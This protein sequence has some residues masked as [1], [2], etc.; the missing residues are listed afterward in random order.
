MVVLNG[1]HV[2]VVRNINNV[3][4]NKP[5]KPRKHKGFRGF[6]WIQFFLY[7]FGQNRD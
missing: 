1:R 3:V 5:R 7:Y 6:S 4:A 2:A